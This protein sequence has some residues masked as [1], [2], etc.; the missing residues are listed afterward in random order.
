MAA[1]RVVPT[2]FEP[3]LP[4]RLGDYELLS[5]IGR[6]G[7]GVIYKARQCCLDRFCAVKMLRQDFSCCTP[8]AEAALAAEAAAAGSLD[9]P[10]IVGIYE[11]GREQGQ[12]FFSMEF[13]EG[14]DLARH[15]RSRILDIPTIARWTRILASAVAYAHGR[16]VMHHDLKPANVIIDTQQQPQITDFGLARR[17]DE[18]HRGDPARGAGSP[19]FLAPEQASARFGEPSLLTDVYGIGA[20]LY[21][22][23][24]DRPPHVGVTPEDTIAAVLQTEVVPPRLLRPGIPLDLET[25]CLRCLQKQPERRYSRAQDVAEELDRFLDDRP[26]QARPAGWIE[27]GRK[28]CRRHPAIAALGSVVVLL[29][30]I[31]AFGASFAAMRIDAARERAENSERTTRRSLYNADMLLASAALAQGNDGM[32]RDLLRRH[33]PTPGQSELRGWE[34][35]YLNHATSGDFEAEIGRHSNAVAQ[36]EI[37]SDGAHLLACD[38]SGW[39]RVWHIATRRPVAAKQVNAVG[40]PVFAQARSQPLVAAVRFDAERNQ[41]SL[42]LL[43]L[44]GLEISRTLTIPQRAL[45]GAF[46]ADDTA[47]W[48]VESE[49]I[50]ALRL[51]NG[52]M[53]ARYAVRRPNRWREFA[54][55]RDSRQFAYADPEGRLHVLD[56]SNGQ[57]TA[58]L[59][60]HPFRPVWGA[61]VYSLAFSRDASRLVSSG[62]DGQVKVWDLARGRM[63]RS[64]AAHSDL[65]M[66]AVLSPD[67]RWIASGGRD[68]FLALTDNTAPAV[69]R[70]LRGADSVQTSL[71]FLPD[72]NVPISGALNGSIR[73]WR[74][75]PREIQPR[76]DNLPPE[77]GASQPLERGNHFVCASSGFGLSI[78]R[79]ADGIKV[80]T[81]EAT[82]DRAMVT[83]CETKDGRFL[84]ASITYPGWLRIREFPGDR[85][86]EKRLEL[87]R[88][89]SRGMLMLLEFSHDG[90]WLAVAD[91]LRGVRLLD[92]ETLE[93]RQSF[94]AY[95]R[96][97]A[98][99][100]E[101]SWLAAG[102]VAGM[103]HLW[104]M[105]DGKALTWD[106]N[107]SQTAD[108]AFSPDG[109]QL[110]S[111][112]LDG[113]IR[114]WEPGS[115]HARLEGTSSAGPLYSVAWASDG[116]RLFAGALNGS[117]VVWDA[118]TGRESFV[119][120]GHQHPITGLR[121]MSDGTLVS[122]STDSVLTWPAPPLLPAG[123]SS[124]RDGFQRR[125]AQ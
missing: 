25:I 81:D 39:L 103:L 73:L 29:L 93:T 50:Q 65:V 92:V 74:Q 66:A 112:S 64:I 118:E 7:M 105:E 82:P 80:F 71:A 53:D 101:G 98:F 43:T 79:L 102:S 10:N 68:S 41:A 100:P 115:G 99:S 119:G 108:L 47:L 9:H 61:A 30:A 8:E 78:H 54:F 84:T 17:V 27:R 75:Q 44:P 122:F 58:Q 96:T 12:L 36:I 32:V 16:G 55:S 13:V 63:E 70:R 87:P 31:L 106:W 4:S 124:A 110:A 94:Q 46:T 91:L 23:L 1:P 3:E 60:G 6:G 15:V 56:L 121:S 37:T 24:T 14:E 2:P 67:D 26:I 22:L 90:R 117:L 77:T 62:T 88:A 48:M 11:V 40:A 85:V 97:L 33:T 28:W 5:E 120:A 95:A 19:N 86:R 114:T 72:G 34:W 104:S 59:E 76:L 42:L 18:A 125:H 51:E 38:S 111:I 20:I 116:S 21:F 69:S 35:R 45:P 107:H 123:A 113:T 109:T 49:S 57:T 89:L 83:A 52:S